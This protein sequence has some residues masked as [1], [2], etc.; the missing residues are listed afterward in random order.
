[1]KGDWTM[2]TISKITAAAA[3]LSIAAIPASQAL[4]ASKT[5]NA[6]LGAAIGALGGALVSKGTGGIVAG[7]AAGAAVGII[8]DKPDRPK[9]RS[10]RAPTRSYSQQPVYGR[11]PVYNDRYYGQAYNQNGYRYAQPSRY[12]YGY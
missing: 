5:E 9:Y 11:Q 2:K 4:A 10:Y 7:A 3:A 12:G 6:L 8:A 1:M